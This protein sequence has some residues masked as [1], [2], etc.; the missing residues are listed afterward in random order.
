[1]GGIFFVF[2]ISNLIFKLNV[3]V[4]VK[5]FVLMD[6]IES[7]HYLV[8]NYPQPQVSN[9]QTHFL[10]LE[11]KIYCSSLMNDYFQS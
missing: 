10:S 3:V 11:I 1:M 2:E 4:S 9:V 8:K 6:S 7:V 5:S